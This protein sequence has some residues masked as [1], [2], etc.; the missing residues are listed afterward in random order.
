MEVQQLNKL[1]VDHLRF[2]GYY[3]AARLVESEFKAKLPPANAGTS[4]L[5]GNSFNHHMKVLELVLKG[6]NAPSHISPNKIV[7]PK[8]DHTP[9]IEAGNSSE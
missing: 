7:L 9:T 6:I 5:L 2:Y 8:L 3:L 1:I 4:K